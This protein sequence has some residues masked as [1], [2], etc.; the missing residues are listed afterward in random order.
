MT[1]RIFFII[2]LTLFFSCEVLEAR[3]MRL[4]NI[5]GSVHKIADESS[6]VLTVIACNHPVKLLNRKAE[7]GWHKVKVGK[8][9]G[10][11]HQR[12]LSRR[13]VSCFQDRYT[14]FFEKFNLKVEQTY[15]WGKLY[16]NYLVGKSEV[17]SR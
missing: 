12:M 1:K 11:M 14:K 16:D 6:E 4:K 7:I 8:H 9:T 15:F 13:K 2:S 17:S 10:F 3:V 5:F